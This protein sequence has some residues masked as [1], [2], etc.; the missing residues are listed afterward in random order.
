MTYI[1][2]I[3]ILFWDDEKCYGNMKAISAPNA[4][5]EAPS[6]GRKSWGRDPMGRQQSAD[7]QSADCQWAEM[8]NG[9]K[10]EFF[11][12][13]SNLKKKILKKFKI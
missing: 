12:N 1:I 11:S 8:T 6:I 10:F 5:K 7:C 13:F 4:I 9:P 2:T 3:L